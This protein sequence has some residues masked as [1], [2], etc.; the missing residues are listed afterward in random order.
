[1]SDHD[2]YSDFKMIEKHEW[3]GSASSDRSAFPVD[4]TVVGAF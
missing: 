2:L 1:M 4:E 3:L